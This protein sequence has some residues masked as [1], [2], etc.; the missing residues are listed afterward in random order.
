[1]LLSNEGFSGDLY[2]V[3]TLRVSTTVEQLDLRVVD[4]RL[5]NINGQW[6]VYDVAI[7]SVSLVKN[8]REQFQ[9]IIARSSIKELL[10]KIKE[11]PS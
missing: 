11:E 4:Y 2:D 8:F 9:R 10:Q 1:M 3:N 5:R 7:D 6:R